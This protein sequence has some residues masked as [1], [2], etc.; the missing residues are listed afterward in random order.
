M[1]VVIISVMY[2]VSWLMFRHRIALPGEVYFLHWATMVVSCSLF[3]MLFHCYDSLWRYADGKEYLVLF[4]AMTCGFV[5]Y[6]AVDRFALPYGWHYSGRF[7]L[8]AVM[9]SLIGMWVF[10]FVYR[11]LRQMVMLREYKAREACDVVIVGAGSA[12]SALMEEILRN[13]GAHYRVH[14]F[15]DDSSMKQ[16]AFIHGVPVLG[17]IDQMVEML[18]DT[19]VKEIVVAIPSLTDDERRRVLELCGQTKCKVRIMAQ[20][21]D[22]LSQGSGGLWGSIRDVQPEDLLGREIIHFENEDVYEFLTDKVVMVTGGGGSIGSELCRQIAK[23]QPRKLIIVDIYENNAYDIQQELRREYAGLDLFVEIASVRDENKINYLFRKY[24]PQIVFHAAAHKHVPLMEDCPEEAIK[25]NV[26]G[27]YHVARAARVHGADK[28]ILIS[29]DKAVNPTNVMGA[30]KRLC[31][32]IIQ[33]MQ[34]SEHTKFVAVRFGNVLGSNGSVIPLFKQ[35][36][37]H[38]GPITVTDRRIIR[39]FM[40]IPEAA[41]LV[42]QAGAIADR[43]QV[44]VLDMGEP[45]KILSLA[46]NLVRLAGYTPYQ[47]IDIIETG[48]RPGEKLYEELLMKNEHLTATK[49]QKIFVEQQEII[50][51]QEMQT[52]LQRLRETLALEQPEEIVRLMHEIVPTFKL[53][54]EVNA[55]VGNEPITAR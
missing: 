28:F 55:K 33:S 45:V 38:G 18:K 34:N 50:S 49:N 40:T 26:F 48:L 23:H 54:E 17:T 53:P 21:S 31:E 27:T 22:L 46:E 43:S 42:M 2:V 14:G 36:L 25:N 29:T 6:Y 47:D 4:I 37:A 1:D 52:N 32:M 8:F 11:H 9:M 7:T 5:L 51:E 12:A 30:S 41:Q 35:Q 3:L 19:V 16:G 39:Y 15:F 20:A 13:P 10:R 44:F 24:R